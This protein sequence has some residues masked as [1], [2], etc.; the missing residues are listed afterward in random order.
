MKKFLILC[1][2]ALPLMAEMKVLVFAGSLRTDSYN[3]KLAKEATETIRKFGYDVTYIDLK[4]YPLPFYDADVESQG[5][6]K[7]A[8]KLQDLMIK[9]DWIVIASPE[10]NG[11]I[12]GV[13]K[14]AIDWTSRSSDGSFTTAAFEGK[15]FMLMSASP[16]QRGGAHALVHLREIIEQLGGE[17][18]EKP[19][20][21]PVA[22]AAFTKEGI[23]SLKKELQSEME[24]LF[25]H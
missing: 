1:L 20:S 15:H 24:P 22:H 8:K 11:S 2:M 4:D 6:P 3:K 10:Y 16:G 19:F 5:M 21:V 23:V 14:N 18:S 17:V 9:S 7:M 25:K 12:S 13:L